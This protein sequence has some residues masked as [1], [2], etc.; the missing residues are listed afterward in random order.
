MTDLENKQ[1]KM[2]DQAA[3]MQLASSKGNKSVESRKGGTADIEPMRSPNEPK[4][5]VPTPQPI[6]TNE[7]ISQQRAQ[8]LA[9]QKQVVADDA[10]AQLETKTKD[11]MVGDDIKRSTKPITPMAKRGF[12]PEKYIQQ[13]FDRAAAEKAFDEDATFQ[14]IINKSKDRDKEYDDKAK[15]AS[16]YAKAAA[17]GNMFSA[18][19]QIAGLGKN[20]YVKPN[21]KYLDRVLTKADE[22]RAMYDKIKAAEEEKRTNL[23]RDY[24]AKAEAQH[25]ANEAK[26]EKDINARNAFNYKA[27]QDA[28]DAIRNKA[29][30]KLQQDQL[31]DSRANRKAQQQHQKDV[32][33][34][35]KQK[36]KDAAEAKAVKEA[37]ERQNKLDILAARLKAGTDDKMIQGY[38]RMD[39][40]RIKNGLEPKYEKY[41][42]NVSSAPSIH[43]EEEGGLYSDFTW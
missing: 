33:E 8:N 9:V 24:L 30:L 15:K 14:D 1:K 26:R 36:D 32:F 6:K 28:Q 4:A 27:Y 43:T 34:Y 39:E 18:L 19:G 40:T 10:K 2:L 20:T 31:E 42:N 25:W 13:N 7:E 38:M 21:S 41:Y 23:K 5:T 29:W 16:K 11:M 3:Q 12:K 22:A 37:A 17:W 35:N